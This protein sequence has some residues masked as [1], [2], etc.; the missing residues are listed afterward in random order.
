[1]SPER[2]QPTA[3]PS[4]ADTGKPEGKTLRRNGRKYSAR[5]G[6]KPSE[7]H[8]VSETCRLLKLKPY[9][10]R[11]WEKTFDI[12]VKR[13]SAGRRIYSAAQLEKFRI[14]KHLLRDEKLT[15]KGAQRRFKLLPQTS[16]Q[17]IDFDDRHLQLS[18]IRKELLAI[19]GLLEPED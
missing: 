10:L 6:T 16:Q 7:Y 19:R 8:S 4:K 13:N 12:K 18:W 9:V 1:M 11:Y 17:T 5:P 2:K 14:I 15:I 3:K